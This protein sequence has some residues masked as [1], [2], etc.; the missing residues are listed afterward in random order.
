M[1]GALSS[2]NLWQKWGINQNNQKNCGFIFSFRFGRKNWRERYVFVIS[3]SCL[4]H[5]TPFSLSHGGAA[6]VIPLHLQ[7]SACTRIDIQKL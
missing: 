2:M 3:F 1:Q 6:R 5:L 7:N 4:P